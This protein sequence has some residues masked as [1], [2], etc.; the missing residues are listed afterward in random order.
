MHLKRLVIKR[1]R[2]FASFTWDPHPSVN[3]LIGPG[4]T[5]KSTVLT[6]IATLLAP[7]PLQ[8]ASEFD[9]CRRRVT[10]GFTIEA[11][12]GG[13]DPTIALDTIVP[14]LKGWKDGNP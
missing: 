14:T 8:Q 11:F 10:E 6:A 3:C 2:S 1:Y 5:G 13:C 9:Y 4:D 12:I 7:Y